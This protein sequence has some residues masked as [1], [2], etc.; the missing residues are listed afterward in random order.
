MIK[1]QRKILPPSI[2]ACLFLF[3]ACKHKY[4]Q[5]L[6]LFLQTSEEP[7]ST[8]N[9]TTSLGDK[10]STLQAIPNTMSLTSRIYSGANIIALGSFQSA[11]AKDP[12]LFPISGLLIRPETSVISWHSSKLERF[13]LA[14]G[15]KIIS[16]IGR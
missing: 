10:E 11:V 7:R 9:E 6:G 5:T 3:R 4:P 2:Y 12:T 14:G 8:A 15:L 1:E 16:T 13:I